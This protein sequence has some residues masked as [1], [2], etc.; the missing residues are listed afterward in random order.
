MNNQINAMLDQ[1][2]R[3]INGALAYVGAQN[4]S[5]KERADESTPDSSTYDDKTGTL[6]YQVGVQFKPNLNINARFV[7]TLEPSDTYTIRFIKLLPISHKSGKVSKMLKVIGDVYC[8]Q[9]QTLIEQT[10]DEWVNEH[11]QG[12]IRI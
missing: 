3:G 6:D 2:G 11:Q 7:V 1:M 4:I 8:D 9:L 5:Y 10:Y 12:F